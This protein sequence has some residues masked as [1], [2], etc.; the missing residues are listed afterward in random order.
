MSKQQPSLHKKLSDG[1]YE[2]Y[3]EFFKEGQSSLEQKQLEMQRARSDQMMEM[4]NQES[5]KSQVDIV[6][7]FDE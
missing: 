2:D 7:N 5:P 3:K 4:M 1:K 6:M